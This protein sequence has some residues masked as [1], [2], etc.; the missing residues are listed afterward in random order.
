MT[1]Y[2]L[3]IL[4]YTSNPKTASMNQAVFKTEKECKAWRDN[5]P[6]TV[7]EDNRLIY[8]TA[9]CISSKEGV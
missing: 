6:K 2:I 5:V 8:L 9:T 3:I 1:E 7:I 4:A